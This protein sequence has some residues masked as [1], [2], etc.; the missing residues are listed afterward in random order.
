MSKLSLK[1]IGKKNWILWSVVAILILTGAIFIWAYIPKAESS[2]GIDLSYDQWTISG[3]GA[4]KYI[5]D[6]GD[7]IEIKDDIVGKYVSASKSIASVR[8]GILKL[9]V[10]TPSSSRKGAFHLRLKSGD[11]T[12]FTLTKPRF[13]GKWAFSY[14]GS[15][16]INLMD[17][18]DTEW[19]TII[20]SF[21]LDGSNSEVSVQYNDV[22]KINAQTFQTN[23]VAI[24]N[25][26]YQSGK[27][28][29]PNLTHL[30]FESLT[31]LK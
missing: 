22:Y 4:N 7:Y 20:I 1:Q 24:D 13:S 19:H 27:Y 3:S 25:L 28:Y 15:P 5:K 26:Y 14:E 10:R 12:I 23:Q 16:S 8:V 17:T 18:F 6:K 21:K 2:G 11:K 30:M 31:K 29:T 9:R